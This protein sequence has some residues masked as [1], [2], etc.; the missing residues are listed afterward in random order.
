MEI[1]D[2]YNAIPNS[3]P[4]DKVMINS[5]FARLL[6]IKKLYDMMVDEPAYILE[7]SREGHTRRVKN[8]YWDVLRNETA[9]C[10]AMMAELNLTPKSRKTI[11]SQMKNNS[12]VPNLD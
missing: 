4:V 12:N 3:Q 6:N 1:T 7:E 11:L 2:I 9:G 10:S 5:L 8:P